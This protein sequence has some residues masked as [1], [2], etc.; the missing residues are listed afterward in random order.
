MSVPAWPIPIHQTKLMIANP[1][2]T[3]NIDAPDPG[4]FHDEIGNRDK[5]E[6]EKSERGEKPEPPPARC[7]PREHNRAD[8]VGDRPKRVA[9]WTTDTP[10]RAPQASGPPRG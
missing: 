8:S 5:Q 1:Q 4:A 9:R 10:R 2:P 3:G 7:L 6:I